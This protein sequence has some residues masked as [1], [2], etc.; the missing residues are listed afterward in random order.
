METNRITNP[1]L[2]ESIRDMEGI[3][4]IDILVS[5]LVTLFFIAA[6]IV[7][8]FFLVTGGIKWVTS[9]GD[10]EGTAK[11]RETVTA[12]IIGLVIIF[13]VYAI[14]RLISLFF[15]IDLIHL[16]LEPLVLE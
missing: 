11:A 16:N 13:S 14:L 9:G 4:F 10:R 5:N 15:G 8:L 12:A 1:A 7:A 2:S 3:S 6:A